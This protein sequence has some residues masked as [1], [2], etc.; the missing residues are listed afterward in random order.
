M[1][2]LS[3]G[4]EATLAYEGNERARRISRA[5][6]IAKRILDLVVA[7]PALIVFA[8]LLVA[9]AIVIRIDSPGGA[10]FRQRRLGRHKREF[11]L[12]K[13][14]TMCLD[15]SPERHRDYVAA[16]IA[17]EG[18]AVTSDCGALYKLA[19]DDRVTRVG[20]FLR[21]S[22]IDE[23]PQLWNVVGGHMS[24]VGPRPVIAYEADC[25]PSSYEE[26]FAVKPGLTGLWQVSGRNERTYEEMVGLD[27]EYARRCSLWLDVKI[28]FKTI[29]VVFSRQGVA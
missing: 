14:R 5:T 4:M 6:A 28:L 9:V 27:I 16:L 10:V 26:R 7:V 23:L 8:P 3:S 29:R 18:Q 13:L 25:Y 17:G 22:S 24:L 15:A 1:Q 2:G 12:R 20:R 19:V 21:R 11:T